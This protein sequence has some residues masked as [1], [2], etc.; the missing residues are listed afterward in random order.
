VSD[1]E[2]RSK[3]NKLLAVGY[4]RVVHG[5][6]GDYIEFEKGQIIW[7]NFIVPTS[8]EYRLTEAWRNR[9]YY[10]EYRSTGGS[11]VK[12]YLQYRTVEY[13]DYRVGMC[14][15][16]PQDLVWDGRDLG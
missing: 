2:F 15:M 3:L 7:P 16:S 14:Y 10:A 13:A 12:L 11:Y 8:Q 4:T 5:G 1:L 9:V 6:R